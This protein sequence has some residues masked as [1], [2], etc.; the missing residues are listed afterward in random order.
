[1]S[2]KKRLDLR[3]LIQMSYD[4]IGEIL[5]DPDT[6]L[7]DRIS[8]FRCLAYFKGT[9][10]RKLPESPT[11]ASDAQKLLKAVHQAS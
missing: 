6:T 5:S 11:A 3:D 10:G 9:A 7:K 4:Q 8:L 1:M 2:R